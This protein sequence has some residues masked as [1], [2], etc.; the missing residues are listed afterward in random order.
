MK[1]WNLFLFFCL[2]FISC[3]TSFN[4][5]EKKII[6][7]VFFYSKSNRYWLTKYVALNQQ[8]TN[9]T[10]VKFKHYQ[11]T[12]IFFAIVPLVASRKQHYCFYEYMAHHLERGG[13]CQERWRN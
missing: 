4:I 8:V 6:F 11:I 7:L 10:Y 5:K 12:T 2:S 3:L 13:I 1:T 9:Q